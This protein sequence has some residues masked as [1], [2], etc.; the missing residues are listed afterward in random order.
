MFRITCDFQ[1]TPVGHKQWYVFVSILQRKG[2]HDSIL[3]PSEPEIVA[4]PGPVVNPLPYTPRE[5]SS[6]PA[7]PKKIKKEQRCAYW[8][9]YI[10]IYWHYLSWLHV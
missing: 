3:A 4:C 1:N 6:K 8:V 2:V 7:R 10:I 9:S 5:K